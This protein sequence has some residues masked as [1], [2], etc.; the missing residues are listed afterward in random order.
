MGLYAF[1][2][3]P[4][5]SM[6]RPPKF[7]RPVSEEEALAKQAELAALMDSARYVGD[8]EHKQ[9]ANHD[10]GCV[11]PAHHKRGKTRCDAVNIFE[12]STALRLLREGIAQG[13]VSPYD[14]GTRYPKRI[15]AVSD[16]GDVLEARHSGNGQYHGFPVLDNSAIVDIVKK[17]WKKQESAT[18]HFTGQESLSLFA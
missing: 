2:S 4:Q 16:E 1:H 10:F 6:T 9:N 8:P 7:D 15:W 17:R 11:P 18:K 5:I 14:I 13:L 3:N 12:K